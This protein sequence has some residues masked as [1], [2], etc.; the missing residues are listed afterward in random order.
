MSPI[1]RRLQKIEAVVMPKPAEAITVLVEP[2]EG[3]AAEDVAAYAMDLAS[4]KASGVRTIVVREGVRHGQRYQDGIEYVPTL[5]HA[6]L[7][8]A[9][10]MPSER[11]NASQLC[12]WLQDVS[13]TG[14]EPVKLPA[15]G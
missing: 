10:L 1:E 3:A 8:V 6:G 9:S 7:I 15:G 12:D 4:A 13:G 14:F 11:G 5:V 2:N